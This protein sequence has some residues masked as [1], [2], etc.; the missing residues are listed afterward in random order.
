MR[1][2]TATKVL[3]GVLAA[4]VVGVL[5]TEGRRAA[6]EVL[7][8]ALLIGFFLVLASLREEPRERA[9]RAEARALRM[10]YATKDPFAL[11][12]ES[13]ALFRW[14]QRSSGEVANVLWGPWRGLEVR[15]FDY[16]YTVSEH[17]RRSFSCAL[18]A[19]PEGWPTLAIRR[20]TP[21]TRLADI[22]LPGIEFESDLFNRAYDVRSEDRRFA[23]A[24]VDARMMEWLLTLGRGSGFEIGDRWVLGYREQVQ[25]WELE[26]VLES[27]E[28]FIER[29][30]RAARSMY[31]EALPPRPD[32]RA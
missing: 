28:T 22:A 6:A 16:A 18:V 15:L 19:I 10:Q 7:A 23:S 5:L 27:L 25:P 30:P 21:V 9:L 31:P 20:Q 26:R 17:E 24:L 14:T 1:H 13:F 3:V 8:A 11:L 4:T 32:V 29:I 12:D 2:A